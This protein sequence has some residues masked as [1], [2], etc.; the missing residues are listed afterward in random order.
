MIRA[1]YAY[2]AFLVAFS[3]SSPLTKEITEYRKEYKTEFLNDPRSPLT[4][5]DFDKLDFYAP[6]ARARITASFIPEVNPETFD[7]PTYSGLTRKYRKWG[8]ASFLWGHQKATLSIYENLSLAGNPDFADYLFLPF[9][10]ESNGVTTYGGG[11]YINM[12]K[13]DTE[14]GS[15]TIDFN[16]CYNPYCA[17]SDG[18]NC[19]I[20]PKENNLPFE[21]QAGEKNFRGA[22][23]AVGH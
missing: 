16:K 3:C 18:F 23:T 20:P 10:D 13:K 22:Y 21:I 2:S 1:L 19:P 8:E 12:S 11:R 4:E 6:N 15:I 14:D 17:Y 9:K 7:M 5:S